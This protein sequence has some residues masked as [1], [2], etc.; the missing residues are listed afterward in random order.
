MLIGLGLI[1]FIIWFF[2]GGKKKTAVSAKGNGDTQQIEIEVIG[3]Y[4]PSLISLIKNQPAQLIFHRKETSSCSEEVVLPDFK[5]RQQLPAFQKTVV[6]FT[7]DQAGEFEF[8]CGMGML[9]G[10]IIVR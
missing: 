2:L 7:P 4:T 3:G 1:I 9:H 10:K 5:I 6:E 8:S